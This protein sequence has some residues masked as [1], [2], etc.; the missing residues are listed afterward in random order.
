MKALKSLGIAVAVMLA[1]VA[2]AQTM[3]A[4]E[5]QVAEDIVNAIKVYKDGDI[6]GSKRSFITIYEKNPNNTD[7]MSWLGF[8]HLRTNEPDKA[9]PVLEKVMAAKPDDLEVKNNLGTAYLA[10]DQTDK[11]LE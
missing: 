5:R 2:S 6:E 8:L 10:T 4:E 1:V 3:T 11:A 7:V 9:I